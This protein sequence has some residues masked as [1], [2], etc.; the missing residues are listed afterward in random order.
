MAP[1]PNRCRGWKDVRTIR[2]YPVRETNCK[3][4]W[5][6]R[7]PKNAVTHNSRGV[8]RSRKRFSACDRI[9]AEGPHTRHRGLRERTHA[10]LPWVVP[11]GRTLADGIV[12]LAPSLGLTAFLRS[13][14]AIFVSDRTAFPSE[15]IFPCTRRAPNHSVNVRF[16]HFCSSDGS[17]LV[18][19][20][21]SSTSAP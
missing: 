19:S 6:Y 10:G 2:L 3:R 16:H 7:H 11:S 9:S 18:R 15:R 20:P 8:A 13:G 12:E 21:L 5:R 1:R 14:P 17:S 4:Q